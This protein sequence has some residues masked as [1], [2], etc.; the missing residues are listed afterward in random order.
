MAN[1][2]GDTISRG[3]MTV[4]LSASGLVMLA[5]GGFITFQNNAT[6]RRISD[7]KEELNRIEAE[8]IRKDEL[9]RATE[10]YARKD[11]INRFEAGYLRKDEHNEFKLRLDSEIAAIRDNGFRFISTIVP[12][13]EHEARWAA[14]DKQLHD[15]GER[16]VPRAEN[17]I[18]WMAHEQQLRQ[19]ADRLN[20]LRSATTAT[21]TERDEL[22]RLQEE[23]AQLRIELHGRRAVAPAGP[24]GP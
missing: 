17:E 7:L 22:K 10:N 23:L 11:D 19:L 13:A 8:Y 15:L 18:R 6:D 9:A 3:N 2:R 5:F 4:I 20:E 16:L 24:A 21:Y 12:R 14:T 1:G